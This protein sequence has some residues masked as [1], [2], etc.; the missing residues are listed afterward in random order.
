MPVEL[1]LS[2]VVPIFKRKVGIRKCRCYGAVNLLEHGIK[3]LERVLEKRLR[4]ILS[5]NEMEFGFVH[6]RAPIDAVF[7][8]DGR[9]VSF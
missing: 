2:I 4:R 7:I 3:V 1:A 9:K 6:E 8:L 5:V